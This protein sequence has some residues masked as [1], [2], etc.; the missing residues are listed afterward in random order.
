M[1]YT[2]KTDAMEQA[3]LPALGEYGADFD[4]DG[5]F[6]DAFEYKVDTNEH[7]DQRLN[8]AGFEQV[9]TEAEFWEIAQ[10]HSV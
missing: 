8:T 2:T 6:A 1:R 7:G 3:I 5:I 9:V 10:K 4:A